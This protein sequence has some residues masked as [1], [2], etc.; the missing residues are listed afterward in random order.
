LTIPKNKLVSYPGLETSTNAANL[1]IGQPFTI[2]KAYHYLNV[3]PT[4][5][6]YLFEDQKG[7]ATSLPPFDSALTRIM[8]TSPKFYGG[9]E[10]MIQFKGFELDV[11]FQFT[12]QIKRNYFFGSQPGR[13]SSLASGSL[14]S[15]NQPIWIL[16]RWQKPGD[17]ATIQKYSNSYPIGILAPFNSMTQADVS[18]AD[19]SYI[20]LRNISLYWEIPGNWKQKTHLQNAK[21]YVQGQNLFTITGYKGMDPETGFLGLAP[22]RVI[23]VGVQITL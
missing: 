5:G 22:L 2:T 20:R 21:V 1:I 11:L 9:I 3:D 23:T 7:V 6:L 17:N 19:A 18:Y 12:K 4:T 8:N 13:F 15:N 10:N 14:G 16:D